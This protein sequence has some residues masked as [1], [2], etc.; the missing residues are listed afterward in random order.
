MALTIYRGLEIA[1]L[2]VTVP[3]LVKRFAEE[4]SVYGGDSAQLERIR[5]TIGLHER[6]VVTPEVTALDLAESAARR[7]LESPASPREWSALIFVTQTPD[8]FQPCNAAILHGRLGLSET[9]AAFDVNLGCSGFVYGLWLAG[10]LL[11]GAG[12]RDILLVAGDTMSRCV[13]PRDRS[14]APLFGDAAAA[15]WVRFAPNGFPAWFD[16]RTEGANHR[17]IRIPAGA[18]RHPSG[19]EAESETTDS[20]GNTRSLRH[21]HMDGPEVFNFSLRAAPAS[22]KA[23]MDAAGL[24]ADQIDWFVF[25]QANKY[26]VSNV[27]R[28]LR[29]PPGRA[30][31]QTFEKFGN[32]SGVSIPL[33][34][35]DALAR[36]LRSGPQ[37]LLLGGFGVGLSWAS[38]IVTMGP[39]ACCELGD[40][41]NEM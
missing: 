24:S 11:E 22:A 32:T 21:L 23:V 33:T 25:H 34:I 9:C 16:L 26:I 2:S 7:L 36:P 18:F 12:C 37:R 20:E 41:P 15:A 30:P 5:K 28:R 31:D 38:A 19:P 17:V 6:R 14:V 39:L 4:A 10:A 13:H 1:G 29:V 35:V 3:R 27:A 8:H 40:F